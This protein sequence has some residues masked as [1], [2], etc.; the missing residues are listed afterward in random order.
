MS[1]YIANV[2]QRAIETRRK[3]EAILASASGEMREITREEDAELSELSKDADRYSAE[4]T[5]LG[6]IE[7]RA[8][9][10]DEAR[11]PLASAITRTTGAAM[12]NP[13][14]ID[15]WAGILEVQRTGRS[16]VFDVDVR[17]AA[18]SPAYDTRALA[19]SGGSAVPTDF[20]SSVA[21]YA[22]TFTPMLDPSVVSILGRRTGAPIIMPQLTA[23]PNHGGTV[24]AEAAAI[25]ELDATWHRFS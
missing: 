19:S 3:M 17:E 10:A 2:Y 22:R 4:H 16:V 23:D 24:T 20:A 1:S 25:S 8:K 12:I 18:T 14:D 9:T 7:L 5:R 13:T 15:L 6:A 21:I 11:G